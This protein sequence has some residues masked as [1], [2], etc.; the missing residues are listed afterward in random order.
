MSASDVREMLK[1]H[2]NYSDSTTQIQYFSSNLSE[3][4]RN[5]YI[6]QGS[7]SAN[8]YISWDSNDT[9]VDILRISPDLASHE[10]Q[11]TGIRA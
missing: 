4:F 8:Y 3:Q 2:P 9:T 5:Y 10:S 7:P 11:R 6:A 1:I